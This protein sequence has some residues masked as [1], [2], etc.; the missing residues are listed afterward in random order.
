MAKTSLLKGE[1]K[2]NLQGEVGQA[3]RGTGVGM[4]RLGGFKTRLLLIQQPVWT[5]YLGKIAASRI[6]AGSTAHLSHDS[7]CYNQ[8]Y[9]CMYR[10]F[11]NP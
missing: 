10:I 3:K 2:E 5:N 4:M 8:M 9:V 6:T 11:M 7:A 1:Q